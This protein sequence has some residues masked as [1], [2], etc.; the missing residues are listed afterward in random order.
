[1]AGVTDGS[2]VVGEAAPAWRSTQNGA[3]E[4]LIRAA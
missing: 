2:R 4:S 3:S 1:M